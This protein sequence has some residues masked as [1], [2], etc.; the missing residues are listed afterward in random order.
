MWGNTTRIFSAC[1]CSF[2]NKINFR[3]LT[4][5]Y[6]MKFRSYDGYDGYDANTQEKPQHTKKRWFH[7]GFQWKKRGNC[8]MATL[9]LDY[10]SVNLPFPSCVNPTY[11]AA[12]E[13]W[14]GWA[15]QRHHPSP[16]GSKGFQIRPS[17]IH[18][19]KHQNLSVK[20]QR[21]GFNKGNW[22]EF[23]VYP[24]LLPKDVEKLSSWR[25]NTSSKQRGD[26]R[27]TIFPK[28]Q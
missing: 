8:S 20:K 22:G 16:F 7:D 11:S 24:R 15:W 27:M 2:H 5:Q 13:L 21:G 19:M 28:L 10:W 3:L 23:G 6:L 12:A 17:E 1:F 26:C 4:P 14:R 18:R 9:D 25:T